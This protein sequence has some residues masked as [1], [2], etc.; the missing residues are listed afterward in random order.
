MKSLKK[1][2]LVFIIFLILLGVILNFNN[3][4]RYSRTLRQS[5]FPL[6]REWSTCVDGEILEISTDGHRFILT[7]TNEK[8]SAYDR[9]NGELMWSFPVNGQSESFPSVIADGQVFV[10]DYKYLWSIDLETGTELWQSSLSSSDTWIP[11]ATDSY[12]LL[13]SRSEA[14]DVYDAKSGV[15][16]WGVPVG[17]GYTKAYISSD[18]IYI[19]D[20]GVKAFDAF[21]G[22]VLWQ[23]ENR[24]VTGYS[25]FE[26]DIL[27]YIE[28]P[29][30]NTFD[31]V[32]YDTKLR[33]ELWRTNFLD[34]TPRGLY[35]NGKFLFMAESKMLYQID[36]G[37]G[38]IKW[39][40]VL[41]VPTNLSFIGDN[42]Y[43]LERFY[44]KIYAVN[45]NSGNE[46]GYLQVAPQR[47]VGTETQ[48]MI[49][50]KNDLAFSKGCE[51]FVYGN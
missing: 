1:I 21:T 38:K 41:S 37:T 3:G 47:F 7:K 9:Q 29:G 49:S 32:A 42:V 14:M 10:S 28:Y 43:V 33:T 4:E 11:Y 40:K 17:R 27:F 12:V 36:T 45:I 50:L 23:L 13:N 31:L 26:K 30:D 5:N 25:A 51:V 48:E 34:E 22:N 8:I 16:L 44:R 18:T 39:K 19:V 46:L 20:R 6:K 15:K 2:L 35:A 24:L